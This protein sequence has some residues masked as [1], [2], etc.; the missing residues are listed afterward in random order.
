MHDLSDIM[1]QNILLCYSMCNLGHV[2]ACI[3]TSKYNIFHNELM[4]SLSLHMSHDQ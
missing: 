2:I 1:Y 3:L 4:S